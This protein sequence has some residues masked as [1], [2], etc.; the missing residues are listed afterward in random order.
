MKMFAVSAILCGCANMTPSPFV[1]GEEFVYNDEWG[2]GI[3]VGVAWVPTP[4]PC[5]GGL[6]PASECFRDFEPQEVDPGDP[7][8]GDSQAP[9]WAESL[10]EAISQLEQRLARI[11]TET[12]EAEREI[13]L[14]RQ[15][16]VLPATSETA[17]GEM[18]PKDK[19]GWLLWLWNLP[20][21]VGLLLGLLLGALLGPPII[22]KIEVWVGSR[23]RKKK[24]SSR[25]VA[26]TTK[27]SSGKKRPRQC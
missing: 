1:R 24:A 23:S 21:G 25:K 3:S 13:R 26:A 18:P 4:P 9:S 20:A 11:E 8:S 12:T 7:S 27:K 14:S 2:T 16:E 15:G 5:G 17:S 6:A 10:F 19:E 22:Q